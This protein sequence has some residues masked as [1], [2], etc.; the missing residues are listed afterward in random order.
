MK[1]L[2]IFAFLIVAIY[3]RPQFISFPGISL[4]TSNTNSHAGSFGIPGLW[5]GGG[6]SASAANANAFSL[7][8]GGG[9]IGIPFFG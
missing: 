6:Q 2:I 3:A 9:G 7:N 1:V 5:G 8:L 4:S